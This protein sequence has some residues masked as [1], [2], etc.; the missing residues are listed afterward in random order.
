NR[1][2]FSGGSPSVGTGVAFGNP[3]GLALDA[4]NNRALVIDRVFSGFVAVDLS[5]G[6][7]T[8]FSDGLHNI[9][10]VAFDEA[11]NVAV[12]A[13]F[14]FAAL[15]TVDLENGEWVISSR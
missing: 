12:L 5:T 13:A 14:S 6:N 9:R 7:R 8:M 4:K 2:V 1:S 15:I 3:Q 11:N 10:E